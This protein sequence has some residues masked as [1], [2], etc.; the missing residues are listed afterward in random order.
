MQH[1]SIKCLPYSLF[2]IFF[3]QLCYISYNWIGQLSYMG[4]FYKDIIFF[5]LMQAMKKF[6][7]GDAISAL[8]PNL[9]CTAANHLALEKIFELAAQ[10][11]APHRQNRPSMRT[12]AE[13]LWSIRKDYR[14]QSASDFHS[15]SRS[16]RSASISEE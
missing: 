9:E 14:E 11:L 1:T 3:F 13:I 2:N 12:C 6:T 15:L 16:E 4:A 5:S 8:D 7:D 10:C